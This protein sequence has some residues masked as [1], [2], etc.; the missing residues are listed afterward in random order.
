MRR[1]SPVASAAADTAHFF[2]NTGF[3]DM[4]DTNE[5]PLF[6][7]EKLYLK[8][9]SFES[10]N[11]PTVFQTTVQPTIEVDINLN[12]RQVDEG[13]Y[14]VELALTC[15]AAIT[16]AAAQDDEQDKT[17]Y[18]LVEVVQGGLFTLRHIPEQDLGPLL[19]IE[20]PNILF[21]YARQVVAS[22][23]ADGGFRPVLLNPVNFA[24]MYRE[25][26]HRQPAD[27]A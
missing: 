22:L 9:A 25:Q 19:G 7:I 8:D 27:P 4:A 3:Y 2:F 17:T 5:Q 18:F 10:P 12:T 13:L 1:P 23:T 20:C 6:S 15:T 21:P 26:Q 14:A 16:A 24:A 11:A